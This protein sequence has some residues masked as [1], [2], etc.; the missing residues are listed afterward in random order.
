MNHHPSLTS[1]RAATTA[2]A[3]A[4]PLL[5]LLVLFAPMPGCAASERPRTNGIAQSPSVN[6]QLIG[7]WSLRD[8]RGES[9][10]ERIGGMEVRELPS[11]TIA[12]DGSL[13]GAG[14]V[15]RWNAA[16]DQTD[17]RV[18][19]FRVS[20]IAATRMAGPS[21]LMEIE[22]DYFEALNEASRFDGDRLDEGLL[23]LKNEEGEPVL[24][25]ARGE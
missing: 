2:A 12:E 17:R 1:A 11:M 20:A 3:A 21:R 23:I 4:L 5:M 16:L 25:F 22:R 19:A 6:A 15:N 10:I 9:V 13:S 18:H 24:Q 8:I 7:T 14:G